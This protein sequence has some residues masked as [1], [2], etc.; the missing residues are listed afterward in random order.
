MKGDWKKIVN[1]LPKAGQTV[2]IWDGKE[3]SEWSVNAAWGKTDETFRK[4]CAKHNITHWTERHIPDPP[5]E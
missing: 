3:V 4:H 5:K 2:W 1:D